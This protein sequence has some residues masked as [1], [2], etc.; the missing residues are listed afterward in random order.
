[1]KEKQTLAVI[2]AAVA[3]CLFA[4]CSGLNAQDQWIENW[5]INPDKELNPNTKWLR[6][7]KWGLFSHYMAHQASAPIPE[8]MNSELWNKKVNSFQ[9]KKF[10]D[11][12]E[13]LKVPYFF[14]T[15]GQAGDYFCS[16][17]AT[18]E[19]L[20]G[21]SEGR[22]SKRDLVAELGKEL[23][24]R[25]IRLCVYLP[26][27]GRSDPPETQEKWRQVIRE[28]S[29]RWGKDVHAWWIDGAKFKGPEVFKAYTAAFKSGNPDALVSYNGGPVGMNR[30]QLVPV[31]EHEDYLAGECGFILPTCGTTPESLL[32]RNVYNIYETTDYYQGPNINGDQLHFLTFL[33]SFWGWGEPRFPEA[34]VVGWTQHVN[35]HGGVV[36]WD[37][38]LQDDGII[39]DSFY[40]QITAL[41]EAVIGK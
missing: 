8:H 18:Y 14:I 6:E 34:Y 27:K 39:P 1:M 13:E 28:W 10:A 21:P 30:V 2:I 24:S 32:K 3:A 7:A 37:L 36:T 40:K 33:G 15:I 19:K 31:T 5:Q 41:S 22:I 26:A 4:C 11:Q 35:D 29:M 9:V 38:R 16:P 17:N 12:L 20:F 25:G 23:S